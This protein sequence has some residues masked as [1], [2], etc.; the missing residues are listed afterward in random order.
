MR[1]HPSPWVFSKFGKATRFKPKVPEKLGFQK[2]GGGGRRISTHPEGGGE[3][4]EEGGGGGG[5]G[6][7]GGAPIWGR[8]GRAQGGRGPVALSGPKCPQHPSCSQSFLL[9]G[10][11]QVPTIDLGDVAFPRQVLV[12]LWRKCLFWGGVLPSPTH[13]LSYPAQYKQQ[14]VRR[15]IGHIVVGECGI[16]SGRPWDDDLSICGW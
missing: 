14:L 3:G 13:R 11:D 4:G 2:M 5:R 8:G 6:G 1:D 10:Q 15:G 12:T 7:E 9:W 16:T